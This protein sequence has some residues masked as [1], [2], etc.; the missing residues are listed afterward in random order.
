MLNSFSIFY[1]IKKNDACFKYTAMLFIVNC[2][3]F[4]PM[5]HQQINT[6][7]FFSKLLILLAGILWGC[8]GLFVR[9]LNGKGLTS[10][11]I[12]FLRAIL[13]T[14]FMAFILLKKDRALFKIRLR[15][16]WCFIGTGLLSIVFFGLCYFIEITITSRSVA[17]ILLYTAPAFVMIISAFCFK[18]RLTLKKILALVLSFTGLIFVTGVLGGSGVERLTFTKF[19]IGLGAGLGYALY[20]IFSRFA[21]ERGY[22]SYTISFYTFLF[23]SAGT[24]FFARPFEVAAVVCESVNMLV[25]SVVFALV[26]TVIPYLTYTLGLK[27]V[28]N[29][30]ASIIASVE[31]VVATLNGIIWFHEKMSWSVALGIV[32]V[33]G[34]IVISNLG[35]LGK[36]S[37]K[38]GRTAMKI[39]PFDMKNIPHILDVVVPL[40]SPP[41]GD[42]DFKRFNVEYIVRNNYFENDLHYELVEQDASGKDVFCAM[43]FFAR[44]GDVC[45]PDKWFQIES[46]KFPAEWLKGSQMSREYI[47]LMDRKTFDMMNDDDIKLTLYVSCK[48]GCGSTLLNELCARMKDSGY[49]KLYLWTDCECNWEWY[50]KHG[51]ELVDQSVYEPFSSPDE[52]YKTFVFKKEL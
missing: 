20:S 16:L 42:A 11:D 3:I 27:S 21:I 25:V 18:E 37:K 35:T 34:G 50:T 31:P 52:D 44:K 13:T 14:V 38:K 5:E 24:V 15:D 17:A 1:K 23:A 8:M 19:M 49:K 45:N 48:K 2:A 40:W 43:A 7:S 39:Q 4:N 41:V 9:P 10:W 12:V 6:K 33:L 51:Y 36:D 47:E 29:G 32:L 22:E 30:Q 28:E 26:S 46:K